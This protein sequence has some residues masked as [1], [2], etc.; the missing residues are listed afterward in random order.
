MK[1]IDDIDT[2]DDLNNGDVSRGIGLLKS[3]TLPQFNESSYFN[4]MDWDVENLDVMGRNCF[5]DIRTL[6]KAK[7]KN[8]VDFTNK[9][10]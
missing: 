4:D 6:S 3:H 2:H 5:I 10:G 8:S 1:N 9:K 7:N